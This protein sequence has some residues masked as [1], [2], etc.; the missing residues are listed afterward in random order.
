MGQRPCAVTVNELLQHGNVV[1]GTSTAGERQYLGAIGAHERV[2]GPR[3]IGVALANVGPR[4]AINLDGDKV[5]VHQVDHVLV[6]EGVCF[7]ETTR[8]TPFVSDVN[9]DEL[10]L[11]TRFGNQDVIDLVNANTWVPS[12]RMNAL[13]GHA[14]SE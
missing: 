10:V 4:F 2:G 3:P 9:Q 11:R 8:R 7:H 5:G 12:G 14:Q 1:F 13:A 6:A